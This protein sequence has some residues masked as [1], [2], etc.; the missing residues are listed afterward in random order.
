[1]KFVNILTPKK[2]NIYLKSKNIDDVLKELVEL[3]STDSKISKEEIL[4]ALKEREKIHSTGIGDGIAIPHARV[5]GLD[6]FYGALG[7]SKEGVDFNSIDKKPVN[8]FFVLLSPE[9]NN[10]GKH[11][12][13]LADIA[14]LAQN[15]EVI[16]KLLKSD[17]NSE[18]FEII[19][20]A[21]D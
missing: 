13:L 8:I 21:S 1:M 9:N 19:K 12:E 16:S 18:A 17:S 7:I 20:K 14:K 5:K 10:N 15:K 11:I 3:I 2:V 4:K 6:K